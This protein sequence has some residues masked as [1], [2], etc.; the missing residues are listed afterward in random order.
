MA[1]TFRDWCDA[2]FRCC[3]FSTAISVIVL[4][5]TTSGIHGN[6]T[7]ALKLLLI[8]GLMLFFLYMTIIEDWKNQKVISNA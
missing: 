5:V 2:L 6:T 3:A 7:I 8:S 1:L 4:E